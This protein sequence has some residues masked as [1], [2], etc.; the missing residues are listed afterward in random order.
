MYKHPQGSDILDSLFLVYP[1]HLIKG[2]SHDI[3][4][5]VVF[6]LYQLSMISSKKVAFTFYIVTVNTELERS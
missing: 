4:I 2:S 3:L 6:K 5:I 1:S